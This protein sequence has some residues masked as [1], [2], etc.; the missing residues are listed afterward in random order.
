MQDVLSMVKGAISLPLLLKR[1]LWR[2][3]PL[4]RRVLRGRADCFGQLRS[5]EGL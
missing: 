5:L 4:S 3:R 2:E 1:C